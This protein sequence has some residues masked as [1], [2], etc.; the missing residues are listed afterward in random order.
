M[1]AKGIDTQLQKAIEVA[2]KNVA[3]KGPLYPKV[4][5]QERG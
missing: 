5:E 1:L 3:A 2:M 4:P